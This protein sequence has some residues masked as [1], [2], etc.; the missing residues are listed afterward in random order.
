MAGGTRRPA[1]GFTLIELLIAMAVASLLLSLAWPS[2]RGHVKRAQRAEAAAALLQAQQFM[3]RLYAV[4][5]R[6][7]S[8]NGEAPSL[9]AALQAV[10]PTGQ[11]RYRLRLEWIDPGT[12]LLR[13]EPLAPHT[14]E[15]CGALL[16]SGTGQRGRSGREL[17]VAQCWQ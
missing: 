13:A 16:L 9:P 7:I 3:E 15:A 6:F 11:P 12:Y 17:S 8:A 2:Y 4:Q 14:D 1:G 5:G 10:P